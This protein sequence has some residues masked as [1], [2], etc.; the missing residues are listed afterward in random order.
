M[1]ADACSGQLA[2]GLGIVPIVE[3]PKKEASLCQERCAKWPGPLDHHGQIHALLS[4]PGCCLKKSETALIHDCH[5]CSQ[6]LLLKKKDMI[7]QDSRGYASHI[8]KISIG[9]VVASLGAYHLSILR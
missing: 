9:V 5:H 1:F 7:E 2:R 8:P 3:L 6:V 4:L